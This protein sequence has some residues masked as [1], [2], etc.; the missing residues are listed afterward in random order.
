MIRRLLTRLLIILLA[1][2]VVW[3]WLNR[4]H[5]QAFPSILGA[6]TAKEY[7]S[8]RYVMDNP[9]DY[10]VGYSKQYLPL[11]GFVDDEAN[12]RVTA[13]ALGRSQ[14]AQ[15]LGQRQGCQLLPQAVELTE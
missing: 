13:R 9:A 10:C 15:W 5:L 7:C 1:L 4:D 11:S 2:L 14:S 3:A 8:C 12:K 6:Y